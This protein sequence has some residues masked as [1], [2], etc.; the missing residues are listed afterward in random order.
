[1]WHYLV[2]GE[3]IVNDQMISLNMFHSGAQSM[4]DLQISTE[5]K[6]INILKHRWD[7]F[8]LSFV[9]FFILWTGYVNDS[10]LTF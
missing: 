8:M 5:T 1:M 7:A 2:Q 10:E 3:K 6:W 4:L 9:M